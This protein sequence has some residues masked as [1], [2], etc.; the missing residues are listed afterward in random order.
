MGGLDVTKAALNSLGNWALLTTGFLVVACTSTPGPLYTVTGKTVA[1]PTCPVVSNPPQPGC[2]P[3]PVEGAV[4]VITDAQGD[5]VAR[6][7]SLADGTFAFDIAAGSYT[8]TPEPVE[9]LMGTA[10]PVRFEVDGD[11]ILPELVY[12]T[13]IR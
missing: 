4:I 7:T 2:D 3:R 11:V 12:D 5:E 9:S 10:A 6:V 8:A 1:A 13:G